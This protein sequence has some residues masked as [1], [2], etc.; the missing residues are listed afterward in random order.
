MKTRLL[1]IITQHDNIIGRYVEGIVKS[2][3]HCIYKNVFDNTIT[4]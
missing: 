2:F 4:I 3:N 1:I